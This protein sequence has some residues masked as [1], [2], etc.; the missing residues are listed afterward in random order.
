MAHITLAVATWTARVDAADDD[1][2][3]AI[4]EA[5]EA[6]YGLDAT[7]EPQVRLQNMLEHLVGHVENVARGQLQREAVDA[8]QR[9]DLQRG[10]WRTWGVNKTTPPRR[11]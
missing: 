2:V 10:Q 4:L 11:G 6:A 1:S 7:L 8:A 5:Y 3:I 9:G